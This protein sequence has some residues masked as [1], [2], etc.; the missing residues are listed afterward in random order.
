MTDKILDSAA[1]SILT[2]GFYFITSYSI[3]KVSP[4]IEDVGLLFVI[5][6]VIDLID[7]FTH[8]DTSKH[9][10]II[11]PLITALL[12]TFSQVIKNKKDILFPFLITFL[13]YSTSVS[14]AEQLNNV[15]Y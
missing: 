15:K 6:A 4:S 11:A 14:L 10:Y 12:F 9:H 13:G 3:N 2:S 7:N 8:D 5:S 1:T